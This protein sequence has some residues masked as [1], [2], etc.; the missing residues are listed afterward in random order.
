M[1]AGMQI[2]VH[3]YVGHRWLVRQGETDL[4]SFLAQGGG[5]TELFEGDISANEPSEQ[6]SPE[7]ITRGSAV[8][9]GILHAFQDALP[10]CP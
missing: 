10:S 8:T 9:K 2:E 1:G 6:P 3:T 7:F 4:R 5:S